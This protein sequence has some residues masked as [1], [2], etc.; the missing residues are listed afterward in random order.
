[1]DKFERTVTAVPREDTYVKSDTAA[2]SS[3]VASLFEWMDSLVVALVAVMLLFTLILGKV[4]VSGDSMKNTL[5]NGDQL[6]MSVFN[7]EPKA[8]DIVI[9]STG[10][11]QTE[12]GKKYDKHPLVKR[13]IATEGQ[14][15]EIKD[16]SVFVDGKALAEDY[17]DQSL[18]GGVTEEDN[19]VGKM[20]VPEHCVFVLGDNRPDSADSRIIG[21]IDENY[22]LGKVICRFFPFD[23]IRTF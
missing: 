5:H 11:A 23:D 10:C 16:G 21:F 15:V 3:S 6:L 7:Y 8:G 12:E 20:T 13:I 18:T 9:L 4:E 1:M 2:C 14:S 19:F 22:I 17:L